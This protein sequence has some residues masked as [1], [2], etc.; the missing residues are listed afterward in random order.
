MSRHAIVIGINRYPGMTSLKG[1][2]NDAE[3]FLEWVVEPG[4]GGVPPE[5][6]HKLLSTD[7]PVADDDVTS[8][9]PLSD[10]IEELFTELVGENFYQHTGD[11]LY[12][13]AAGHGMSDIERPE[14]AAIVAA[15]ARTQGVTIPH[16]PITDFIHF[17]HRSYN[18]KEI[19]VFLDCCLD[20]SAMRP[21]RSAGIVLTN[22]HPNANRVKLLIANATLWSKKSFERDF[23]GQYRGI[24]SVALMNALEQLPS[25]NT[26]VTG[27]AIEEYIDLNILSV[28]GD[29]N[30]EKPR[31]TGQSYADLVICEPTQDPAQLAGFSL[32]VDV[33][34]SA[35]N[36]TVDLYKNTLE[37]LFSAPVVDGSVTFTVPAGLYKL[38][39]RGTDR[40]SLVEVVSDH[41]TNL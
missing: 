24:F 14:S 36:E 5:N 26:P 2:C 7:I 20:A 37:L 39:L 11:R 35:N 30:I 22:P 6:V 8:A 40:S 25:Q 23:G 9:R 32:K 41:A 17:F 34:G 1:P 29:M 38:A 13:F 28:A 19:L 4:P 15:N 18:F 10:Q 16:S 33:D 27:R 31:F 3:A 12:V 21:L